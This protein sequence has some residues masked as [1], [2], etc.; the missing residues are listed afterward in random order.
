MSTQRILTYY[1][2]GV[3]HFL[4]PSK[5]A[6]GLQTGFIKFDEMTG[7]LREGDL[8][9]LAARPAM[10]KSSL[11]LGLGFNIATHKTKPKGV[12]LFSLEIRKSR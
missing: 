11:A 10:G 3:E 1:P 4:D 7:G 9:I 8:F 2:G 5:A 12:A 6:L